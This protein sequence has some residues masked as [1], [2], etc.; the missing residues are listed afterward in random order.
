[1]SREIALLAAL[2][3]AVTLTACGKREPASPP[4]KAP[5]TRSSVESLISTPPPPPPTLT[6]AQP[7]V[8]AQPEAPQ[9]NWFSRK[10]VAEKQEIM[11]GWL[12]QYQ[13]KDAKAR[14]AVL[15]QI[16]LSKLSAAD[17]AQLESIRTRLKYPP[18]P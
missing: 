3:L 5:E 13:S 17:R 6:P 8:E 14:A 10:T 2:A 7:N 4:P 11:E 15:E 16:N 18:I 1:M 9:G 12:Y